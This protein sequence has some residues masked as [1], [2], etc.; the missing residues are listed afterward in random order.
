MKAF[1]VES[2]Q[3]PAISGSFRVNPVY[4]RN[5]ISDAVQDGLESPRMFAL[6]ELDD[7][8]EVVAVDIKVL[9]RPRH[10]Q[11]ARR[12]RGEVAEIPSLDKTAKVGDSR[13]LF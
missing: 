1:V 5:F 6:H 3:Q 13:M 8:A 4:A 10:R 2:E 11:A 7:I 12:V 9:L